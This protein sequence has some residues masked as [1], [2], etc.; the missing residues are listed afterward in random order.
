MCGTMTYE[1]YILEEKIMVL[2]APNQVKFDATLPEH[3]AAYVQFMKNGRWPITFEVEWPF[4]NVP[5]MVMFKLAQFACL[6][7]GEISS[8]SLFKTPAMA[9]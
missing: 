2:Q 4:T 1:C 8:P 3:R 5:S 7:E 6:S 9:A